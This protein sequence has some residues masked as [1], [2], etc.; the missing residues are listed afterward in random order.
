MHKRKII[1]N[2]KDITRRRATGIGRH[3][4][5]VI[6][7]FKEIKE[8]EL[9]VAIP[10]SIKFYRAFW[11]HFILSIIC[12]KQSA[13]ILFCPNIIIPFCPIQKSTKIITTIHDL[14]WQY[15]PTTLKWHLRVY[16]DLM[17]KKAIRDSVII[18]AISE[19]VKST[20]I[21]K[22]PNAYNKVR[23]V[24]QFLDLTKFKFL[25]LKRHKIILFVGSIA[26]HKNIHGMLIAF[27]K[28]YSKIPH[29]LIIVGSKESVLPAGKETEKILNTIPINRIEFIGYI[30]DEEILQL[31]NES[32]FFVFP[33]FY[34]GFGFTVLEA[35]AC[36]C[37]VIASNI[38]SLPEVC[39]DA[40]LYC[41]PYDTNDIADKILKLAMGANLKEVLRGKGFQRVKQFNSENTAKEYIKIFNDVLSPD[42]A[43][44]G[45]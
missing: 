30:S 23:V 20:I 12:K 14:R 37:P 36:G 26:E 35:M 40:V 38:A 31:Y 17:V 18:I 28:I 9:I 8:F 11:E 15:Y 1:I 34:E 41:N 32:D 29:K 33:S 4:N 10:K 39:G 16:F 2:A 44:C 27:S 13:D 7:L 5:N 43:R 21:D 19:Y 3:I 45:G 6:K 42:L 24:Y 22:Y 25:N